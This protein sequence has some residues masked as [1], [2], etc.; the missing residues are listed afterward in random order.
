MRDNRAARTPAHNS[1]DLLTYL[2]A[3]LLQAKG[4]LLRTWAWRYFSALPVAIA[5]VPRPRNGFHVCV[6]GDMHLG[7]REGSGCHV[8]HDGS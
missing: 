4:E 6:L 7:E 2:L 5:L 3:V 1:C 8:I